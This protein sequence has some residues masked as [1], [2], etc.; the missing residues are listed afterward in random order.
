MKK[1]VILQPSYIPWRGYFHLIQKSDVFIFYDDVQ[2]DKHGWR[3]RN[4]VK[5]RIGSQWLTIPVHSRGNVL[6]HTPINRILIDWKQPWARKHHETLKQNYARSPFYAEYT[7]M[8]NQFFSHR[9]EFLS[10]FTIEI[11]I[12]IARALGIEH[13]VFLRS[14]ELA[15]AQSGA[16]SPTE[17]L[18][19]I[20]KSVGSDHYISG[21]AAKDYLDTEKLKASGIAVEWMVY[22]YPCYDQLYPPFDPFVTVL[23]LMF[24]QGANASAYIW[25]QPAAGAQK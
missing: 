14:S 17:R 1:C 16:S 7:S 20:I 5:S 9:H 3:N 15:P 23:D 6:E 4:R 11:T 19:D 10:D 21:P 25:R 22:D 2:Y 18:V 12:A 24:M 8:L 13:T